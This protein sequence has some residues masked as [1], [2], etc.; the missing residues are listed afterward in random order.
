MARLTV[1]P[2]SIDGRVLAFTM[3]LSL[4]TGLLFGL[5]PALRSSRLDLSEALK[6]GGRGT[7]GSLRRNRLRAALVA[8]EMAFASMLLIGAGLLIKSLVHLEHVPAGFQPDRI[9]TMRVNLTGLRDAKPEQQAAAWSEL[10]RHVE[11]VPGV[12]SV[13]SIAFLPLSQIQPATGFWVDGRPVPKPGSEPVTWVSVVTPGYWST[14]GIPLIR[15]R[16]LGSQRPF[17]LTASHGDQ[18]NSGAGFL[19]RTATRSDRSFSCNGAARLPTRLWAWWATCALRVWTRTRCRRCT[20]RMHRKPNG[21]GAIVIRTGVEPMALAR[22]CGN[23]DSHLLQRSAGGERAAHAAAS[24]REPLP[25]RV[26]NRHCWR[27]SRVLRCCWRRS[28]FSA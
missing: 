5:L 24:H 22:S 4:A 7:Q 28:A 23:A 19:S 1:N 17:R 21:G 10:L 8:T 14:M 13:G 16:V 26:S 11:Q 6:E 15:G 25:V 3:A 27:C 20:S 12:K 18:S 2:V 9:L